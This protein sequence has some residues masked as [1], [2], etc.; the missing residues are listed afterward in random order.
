MKPLRH[1]SAAEVTAAMPPLP[2]RLALAERTMRALGISAELPPKIGVHPRQA[3][4]LAHAMPA[5]LRGEAA[6]GSRTWSGR[7]GSPDSR[8]TRGSGCRRTT[9]WSCSTTP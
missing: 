6:N 1:L 4:S 3:G 9:P 8:P 2:E 7:S 5:L